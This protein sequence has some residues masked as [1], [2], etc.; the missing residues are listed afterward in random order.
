MTSLVSGLGL[1]F[2]SHPKDSGC[3]DRTRNLR[4]T[5][6]SIWASLQVNKDDVTLR[7]RRHFVDLLRKKF[8]YKEITGFRGMTHDGHLTL[9]E[10]SGSW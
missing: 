10:W 4:I 1:G 5:R 3:G 7:H 2:K 8:A 6:S 9:T